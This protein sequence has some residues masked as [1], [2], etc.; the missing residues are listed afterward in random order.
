MAT[1]ARILIVG[2][3]IAG[4]TL[5]TSLQ[6]QGFH[7]ELV[8]RNPEW[9]AEGAG[10][11]VHANGIRVLRALGLG[12][13]VEQ[14]GAVIRRYGWYDQQWKEL[15][16]T[17]LEELWGEVGPCIGIDRPVLQQALLVGAADVP[18][19]LGVAV[20]S[21]TQEAEQ[22]R[23]GFSDG[24][25]RDYDLVV[26]ADGIASTVRQ[27]MLGADSPHYT[28]LMLW[29]SLIPTRPP[30]VTHWMFL[31]GEEVGF[32]LVPMGDGRTYGAGQVSGPRFHDPLAG[33]LERVRQRFAAFGGPVPAYLAALTRDEQLDCRPI[34]WVEVAQWHSGRVVLIGDAAH[35]APPT[36][37]EGGSM[38]ME[39][40]LVLAEV[41]HT[42]ESVERALDTYVARRRPRVDWVAQQSR[43]IA[44]NF[45]LPPAVFAA[46]LCER[47][48]QQMHDRY[49]PLVPAP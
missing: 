9:Q 28:G 23:V 1:V 40:A 17:D 34:E 21:L 33:R 48:D 19:R 20:T 13:A 8:E 27:L 26:G 5:A 7:P 2:G 3:G 18:C 46:A 42:A 14:A 16:E 37:G 35:A 12:A 43:E 15:T 10:I 31:I 39:D 4:L 30:G 22:V 44:T 6:Q 32:L 47:G 36:M 41:L 45:R 24:S 25:S 11:L 29:R 49:R 38:A